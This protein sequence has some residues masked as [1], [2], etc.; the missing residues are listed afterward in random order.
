ML[1]KISGSITCL[2]FGD[3]TPQAETILVTVTAVTDA[4]EGEAASV[5]I[6]TVTDLPESGGGGGGGGSDTGLIVGIAVIGGL[7]ALTLFGIAGFAIY[8]RR[9]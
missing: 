2:P 3:S 8:K 4:V 1:C 9:K 5:A 7:F 6:F